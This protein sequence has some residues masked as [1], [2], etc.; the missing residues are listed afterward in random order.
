MEQRG[1]ENERVPEGG[2]PTR[3]GGRIGMMA[4]A[5]GLV[6]AGLA[7]HQRHSQEGSHLVPPVAAQEQ[8]GR[9][10]ALTVAPTLTPR[11]LEV[12]GSVQAELETSL[13]ARMTARVQQVLV[14]EGDRVRRGQPV[15]LLDARDLDASL[16]QAN[17]NLGAAKAGYDN[18]RIAARMETAQSTARIADAQARLAASEAALGAAN[19]KL[20]LVQ[21]GPRRQERSQ[22]ALAVGQA[23][24]NFKLAESNWRR[25]ATLYD[26]GAISAQQADAYRV[27]FEVAK[28][29]LETAK[30]G[31][32]LTDEG[33]RTEE[34][35]AAEQ[36][37]RQAQAG[38]KEA[39]AG[40]KTAQAAALQT[41]LRKQEIK[42][43]AAQIGQSRASLDLAQV[44]R[45][46]A[47]IVASFDG[48]VT[49]RTAD[50]GAMASP[51]VPLLTIQGGTLR[52]EA[53]VPESALVALRTGLTLPVR[54]DA[55]H[56]RSLQGRVVEIAPQ[57]DA[58]SHTFLVKIDLPKNSGA[59]PGM[60]GRTRL[61]L[62]TEKRLLIPATALSEREGLH[63]LYV[64]DANHIAHLRMVTLG[65]PVGDRVPILSGLNAGERIATEGRE[66]LED[67]RGVQE[68]TR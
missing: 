34:I 23:Q 7:W 36:A 65:A 24:S 32:S 42:S 51:G 67:G 28:A 9:V 16:S 41:A 5:F 29:Q 30:Q 58:N 39:E 68:E 20:Q 60:F 62:G 33:S 14:R 12:S 63:Y 61:T 45:G 64:I 37:V 1:K 6:L 46:Y 18:A 27:Q 3:R 31:Q 15:I 47:Q 25:M 17:A 44:N 8:I 57:G 19:A 43:A 66:G 38:V 10:T 52:L 54:L 2:K 35:R 21:A 49:R 40:L 59:A 56:N 55:L 48:V 53:V 11:T 13:S 26:E 22:A 50:P 4:A